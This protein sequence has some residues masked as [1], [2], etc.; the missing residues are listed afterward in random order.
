[1][2]GFEFEQGVRAVMVAYEHADAALAKRMDDIGD[3]LQAYHEACKN[4]TVVIDEDDYTRDVYLEHE[5]KEIARANQLLRQSIL[6]MLFHFWEKQVGRWAQFEG[7]KVPRNYKDQK[8]YICKKMNYNCK[9][10]LLHELVLIIK[11]D[12]HNAI[13][14][15]RRAE[16]IWYHWERHDLFGETEAGNASGHLNQP[17][18]YLYL[19][20]VHV[21]EFRAAVLESG[22]NSRSVDFDLKAKLKK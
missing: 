8:A 9:L 19:S 13:D 14:S 4:G 21:K 12:D 1:M 7:K 2:W 15:K 3:E 20:D 18:D 10:D 22:P 6:I 16:T 11:H 5:K 17:Y